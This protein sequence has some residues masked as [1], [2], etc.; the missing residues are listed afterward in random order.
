VTKKEELKQKLWD[1][2]VPL[3]CN[4]WNKA[5]VKNGGYYVGKRL[6]YADIALA[7]V[8]DLHL[9]AVGVADKYPL[10]VTHYKTVQNLPGIKEWVA[11]RPVTDW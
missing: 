6:S 8:L 7:A 4:T 10:L 9:N 3:Y 1:E 5:L 2:T 11:K